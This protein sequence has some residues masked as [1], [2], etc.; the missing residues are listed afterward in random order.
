M[1]E[2]RNVSPENKLRAV[3]EYLTGIGNIQSVVARKYDVSYEAFRKWIAKY[4]VFGDTALL[5]NQKNK[6]YTIAFKETI[7]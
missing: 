2:N 1:S 6:N 7:V 5:P 3:Q 4:K